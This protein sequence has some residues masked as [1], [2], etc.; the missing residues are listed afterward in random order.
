[1]ADYP[2]W[3]KIPEAHAEH[4]GAPMIV[5]SEAEEL[6][7]LEGR[8][9]IIHVKDANYD[10]VQHFVGQIAPKSNTVSKSRRTE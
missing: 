1:M 2:K 10:A 4:P 3:I 9:E 8:A 5:N 6:A 7:V